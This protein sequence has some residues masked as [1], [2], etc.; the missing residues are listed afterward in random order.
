MPCGRCR[1]LV[2][3]KKKKT[4]G[5]ERKEVPCTWKGGLC[6]MKWQSQARQLTPCRETLWDA[7]WRRTLDK[8]MERQDKEENLQK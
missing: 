6:G 1:M 5:I 3:Q 4:E 8:G 2:S 7:G